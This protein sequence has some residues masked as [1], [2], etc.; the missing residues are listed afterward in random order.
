[1]RRDDIRVRPRVHLLRLE[2]QLLVARHQR[3]CLVHA[4]SYQTRGIVRV[5]FNNSASV[6][7]SP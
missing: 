6:S 5:H 4:S 1:M 2:Q 7:V 3:R